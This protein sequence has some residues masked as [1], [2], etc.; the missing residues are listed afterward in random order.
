M[1]AAADGEAGLWA[2]AAASA[3]DT[4][5]TRVWLAGCDGQ[6]RVE[7]FGPII[8]P[9]NSAG[10]PGARAAGTK[11]RAVLPIQFCG[12]GA[13]AAA[14]LVFNELE[15]DATEL[16]FANHW[17]EWRARRLGSTDP[18]GLV[19]RRPAIAACSPPD[20]VAACIAVQPIAAATAGGERGYLIVE[21][22]SAARLAT[23]EPDYAL[24]AGAT[25]RALV[26]TAADP[27][28]AGTGFAFRYFAPQYGPPEDAA[29]GSAAVQLAAYWEPR[30]GSARL[31]AR[32]LSAQGARMRLDC[33]AAT[34]ELRGRV[35]Y[36]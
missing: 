24:L 29:T 18:V 32:Q 35:A 27:D 9:I 34:V 20:F 5:V 26:V 13:L 17:Q 8:G 25:G 14:F 3:R 15:P 19:F 1:A 31:E 28:A 30:L 36:G 12:H 16:R 33:T 2:G 4:A 22:A 23:L 6:Y 21:L 10:R 11:R 7:S